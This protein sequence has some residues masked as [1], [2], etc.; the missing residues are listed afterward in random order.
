MAIRSGIADELGIKLLDVGY[1]WGS[2]Q[3]EIYRALFAATA[4]GPQAQH[5]LAVLRHAEEVTGNVAL[6]CRYYGISRTCF[7]KWL[8]RY[9]D[10][11]LEGLRDRSSRQAS[12]LPPRHR[13][14]RRQQDRPTCGSTTTSTR[15]SRCT[16]SGTTASTSPAPSA[17]YRILKKPG[18][19]RLPASQRYK[20]H[21]PSA[22]PAT[23][24]SSPATA[25][26][27]T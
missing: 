13:S 14:R 27:S 9:R 2:E 12:P 6:T 16:S 26:R 7:Y 17:V 21:A 1:T 18:T 20:R 5:R 4:A 10:E 11:G 24:S 23:R 15:R 8:R 3:T 19:N 22:A 25:S